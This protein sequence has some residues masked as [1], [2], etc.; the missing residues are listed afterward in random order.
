MSAKL[1]SPNW[2][3]ARTQGGKSSIALTSRPISVT[4]GL[5]EYVSTL[6]A[7]GKGEFDVV[8]V[9]L[10]GAIQVVRA[11]RGHYALVTPLYHSKIRSS[12]KICT[13]AKKRR[14]RELS[15]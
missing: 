15:V 5:K 8:I 2:H 1:W 14:R 10:N 13:E 12:P 7:A 3:V 11:P 9:Q 4:T 6:E